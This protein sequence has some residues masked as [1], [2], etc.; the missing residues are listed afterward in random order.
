VFLR[1]LEYYSGIIFLTTNRVL[2]FD[3]AALDRMMLIIGYT[4][5]NEE[6][7]R[8]IRESC[9]GRIDGSERFNLTPKARSAF[10]VIDT[11]KYEWSGRE[12][13]SGRYIES[14]VEVHAYK[15]VVLKHASVLAEY[16]GGEGV[17]I[18][19]INDGHVER[20][21]KMIQ[22][23]EKFFSGR[24]KKKKTGRYVEDGLV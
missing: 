12:I 18:I 7:K 11:D 16:D 17:S 22:E 1:A 23:T 10:S 19:E 4:S 8:Q 3:A 13:N 15:A 5:P 6:V 14:R 9:I 24:L 21:I 20:A 2:S